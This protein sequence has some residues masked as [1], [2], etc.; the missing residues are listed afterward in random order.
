MDVW[1]NIVMPDH[2]LATNELGWGKIKVRN[3]L[4]TD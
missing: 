4:L 2:F 1:N 3:M